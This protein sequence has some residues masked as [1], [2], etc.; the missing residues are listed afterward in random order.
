VQ[1]PEIPLLLRGGQKPVKVGREDI[2]WKLSGS[3]EEA[4]AF[5]PK[6]QT[7][8]CIT[9][10]EKRISVECKYTADLFETQRLEG[11]QKLRSGHLYQVNS[12]LENL[13]DIPLNAACRAIL[14]YPVPMRS[15]EA[16]FREGGQAVSVRTV[17]LYQDWQDMESSLLKLI[18]LSAD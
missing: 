10:D 7:D 9:T 3:S 4:Q 18:S 14:L 11:T 6:M 2:R 13:P 5:L 8:V 1:Y 15:F 12:Y 16:D 17:N